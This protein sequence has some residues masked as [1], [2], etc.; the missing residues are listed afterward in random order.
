MGIVVRTWFGVFGKGKEM[1]VE[2][3]L[4]GLAY[5]SRI[6][7]RCMRVSVCFVPS[8]CGACVSF[9]IERSILLSTG[10]EGRVIV[11]LYAT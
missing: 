8:A 6:T 11:Q 3:R 2:G 5:Y 7:Y 4:V 10:E 1:R 9:L